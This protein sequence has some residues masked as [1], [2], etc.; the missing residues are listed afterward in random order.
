[1]VDPRPCVCIT[2]ASGLLGRALVEECLQQRFSVL[3]HYHTNPGKNHQGC[4]WLQ[5]D[6]STLAGIRHFLKSHQTELSNCHFL[7]NNYGPI[8]EKPVGELQAEDLQHDFYHNVVSAFE[9]TLFFLDSAALEVVVWMGFAG[10]EEIKPYRRILTYA[11]AKHSLVLLNRS[12]A[13]K[14]PDIR[15]HMVSPATLKG[16][17]VRSRNGIETPP[18]QVAR[19]VVG[20][21]KNE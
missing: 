16:A 13:V 5:G 4:Q 19:E 12:L 17:V 7:I 20:F 11:M 3:A 2:G 1:M 9:I 10:V 18:R 15:F 6:F 14:Y 8:T 21:L